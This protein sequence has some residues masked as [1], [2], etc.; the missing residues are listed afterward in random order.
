MSVNL[1][2]PPPGLE[3]VDDDVRL[4]RYDEWDKGLVNLA[5][6]M[7]TVKDESDDR[8]HSKKPCSDCLKGVRHVTEHWFMAMHVKARA[9]LARAEKEGIELPMVNLHEAFFIASSLLDPATSVQIED[10]GAA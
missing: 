7:C 1:E 9:V 4:M 8:G 5:R 10:W 2:E 6:S 3:L